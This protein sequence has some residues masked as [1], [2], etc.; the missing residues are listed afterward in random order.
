MKNFPIIKD[1]KEYWVSRSIAVVTYVF[2][3]INGVTHVLANKRGS[4]LPNNVGKWNA[5]SGFLDYGE[6]LEQCAKREIFEETGIVIKDSDALTC[7]EIDSS[8]SREKEVVLVRYTHLYKGDTNSLTNEFSE[9]NEV[10]EIKWIPISEIGN[11]EWVS[12]AHV[13]ALLTAYRISRREID[14]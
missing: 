4:G 1:G 2:A 8:P 11:Y 12:R 10:D 5:P 6:T 14:H 9:A 7:F 13:D 3:I